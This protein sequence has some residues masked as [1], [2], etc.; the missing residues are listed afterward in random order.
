MP[1]H[2]NAAAFTDPTSFATTLLVA[3]L[4]Q[5][6]A[7]WEP[8]DEDDRGP[9][10]WDPVTI[11]HELID[12]YGVAPDPLAFDKLMAGIALLTTDSFY[13]VTRDFIDL[14]NVLS[15]SGLLEEF[16]PADVDE[17]AWGIT[18]AALVHPPE[19]EEQVFAP[20][21][22][23]YIGVML[24]E[25]GFLEAPDVLQVAVRPHLAQL[26]WSDRPELDS[27]IRQVAEARRRNI[28][29]MILDNLEALTA[30][31]EALELQHGKVQEVVR[32]VTQFARNRRQQ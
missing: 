21:I 15:G 30:Q 5:F 31:L 24:D 16:D 17:M 2:P 27:M 10:D 23:R 7:D 22:R 8:E 3:F 19:G 4:D 28:E 13:V 6:V 26:D 18:E 14:C 25:E 32:K 11:Y 1:R 20:E 12:T 9:L 29:E